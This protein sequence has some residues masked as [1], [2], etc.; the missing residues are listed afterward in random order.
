MLTSS[1]LQPK[2]DV[3]KIGHHGSKSSTTSAFLKTV[4]PKYAV[5][6]VG[7][8]NEYG[9]PAVQILDRLAQAGVKVFRTD[10]SGT[11]V[12][13]TDGETIKIDKHASPVKPN[14]P[15]QTSS[16]NVNEL[17]VSEAKSSQ[18]N[19]SDLTV[20][21]TKTGKKYHLDGCQSLSKSKIPITLKEAKAKGYSPCGLCK[22]PNEN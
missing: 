13:T 8:G 11:I 4:S 15:P 17:A 22:P 9:H 5:I 6:S 19:D 21:I 14:A 12:A 16:T 10:E 1:S 20:Y 3:L 7:K 2:V 18:S